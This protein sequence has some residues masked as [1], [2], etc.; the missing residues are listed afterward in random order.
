MSCL[1][2]IKWQYP[3]AAN[4]APNPCDW[5][6]LHGL[7]LCPG[8]GVNRN[9]WICVRPSDELHFVVRYSYSYFDRYLYRK[10]RQER[11]RTS[12]VCLWNRVRHRRIRGSLGY[13][14]NHESHDGVRGDEGPHLRN[15]HG[16]RLDRR[17]LRRYRE[18][19]WI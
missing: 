5:S 19:R 4:S 17:A 2:L 6:D 7:D 12:A 10:G 14:R 16:C 3:Q 13:F 15:F 11:R 18:T 8:W 1:T 9:L